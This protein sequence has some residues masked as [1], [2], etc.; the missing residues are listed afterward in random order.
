MH[1]FFRDLLTA[2]GQEA[3]ETGMK[4]VRAGA[5]ELLDD[6]D[7]RV[8]GVQTRVRE[9]REKVGTSTKKKSS[10][11]RGSKAKKSA[12]SEREVVVIDAEVVD[13]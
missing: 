1:P 9:A 4:I 11:L 3:H 2:I 8:T 13:E 7:E 12:A 10:R 5:A 6:I